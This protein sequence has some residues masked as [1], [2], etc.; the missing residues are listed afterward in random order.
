[1][2]LQRRLALF[3]LMLFTVL[4]AITQ[5]AVGDT[6]IFP[7]FSLSGLYGAISILT[8]QYTA[9]YYAKLI[10]GIEP[11][12]SRYAFWI[13]STTLFSLLT[14]GF[15]GIVSILLVSEHGTLQR[16]S[17]QP[18]GDWRILFAILAISLLI[19]FNNRKYYQ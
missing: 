13:S 15:Y 6:W 7:L 8:W 3:F 18:P 11:S 17:I 19:S 2:R 14:I 9:P 5:F 12:K 1:M 16:A 4:G 10:F